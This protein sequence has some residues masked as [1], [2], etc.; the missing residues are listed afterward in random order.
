MTAQQAAAPEVDMADFNPSTEAPSTPTQSSDASAPRRR[1]LLGPRLDLLLG[2]A[3]LA[4]ISLGLWEWGGRTGLVSPLFFSYPSAI[5][6]ALIEGVRGDL[7]TLDARYTVIAAVVGFV[8]AAA[9]G[10]IVAFGLSQVPYLRKLLS[11]IFTAFN[12][13]PRVALAPLFVL[14][15]GIGGLSHVVLAASLTF[16]VVFANTMAGIESVDQD[17]LLLARLQ[18]ATR[19]QTFRWFVVPSALPSIFVGLELGFIFGMLG[20]V[21]GEM[22]VGEAGFGVRLQRDA[23]IFNTKGYFATLLVLV[24]LSSIASGLFQLAKRPLVRWQSVHLLR[25][26]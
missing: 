6:S 1:G 5:G 25:R 17:H 12:S 9:A 24:L 19:W 7:I 14:W 13:L 8:T 23:G 4:A 22:I 15:F 26:M 18:G 2:W 16:F 11:P 10:V 3:V 20:T 21:S